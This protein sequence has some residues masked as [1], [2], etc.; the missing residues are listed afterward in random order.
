MPLQL[1]PSGNM[2]KT[3]PEVCFTGLL[4]VPNSVKVIMKMATSD[5]CLHYLF[6]HPA[7]SL[8]PKAFM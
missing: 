7:K 8:I 5:S 2:H 1:I 6:P 3:H 4:L